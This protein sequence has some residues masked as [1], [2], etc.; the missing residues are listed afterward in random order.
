MWPTSREQNLY[1]FSFCTQNR[2]GQIRQINIKVLNI[3]IIL[4]LNTIFS[5]TPRIFL[6]TSYLVNSFPLGHL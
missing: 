5:K 2:K 3:V 4:P 1:K 6:Q